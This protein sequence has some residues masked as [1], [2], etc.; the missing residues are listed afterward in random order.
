MTLRSWLPAILLCPV[1]FGAAS[2]STVTDVCNLVNTAVARHWND[3]QLSK[4]LHKLKLSEGLEQHVME[5]LESIFPGPKTSEELQRLH[6]ESQ[7]LKEAT[8]IPNFPAPGPMPDYAERRRILTEA[9]KNSMSYATSMPDFL[10]TQTVRRF[11][12]WNGKENWDLKDTLVI[13]LSYLDH[14]EDYKL[15]TVNGHQTKLNYE[16]LRGAITEGEFVSMLVNLFGSHAE[17]F[18]DHWTMLRKRPAYVFRFQI[19]QKD[20]NYRM[21]FGMEGLTRQSAVAG[22]HGFVY[23]DRETNRVVRVISE[24]DTLPPDFPVRSS[25]T[26]LDYDFVDISG[27]QFLLPL[28]ADARM[29]TIQVKTRNVMD[30]T[31]YRKFA[32]E[33]TITYEALPDDPAKEKDKPPP[34]KK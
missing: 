17:F 32:G 1:I 30:F 13:K 15:L 11:E 28:H 14:V 24:A 6:D 31:A 3:G 25:R 20:S 19:K 5:E 22:Q 12:D 34:V 23:V 10:C 21:D 9:G 33:S 2:L 18:W 7:T 16:N 27:R 29:A 8:D 4:A 26:V